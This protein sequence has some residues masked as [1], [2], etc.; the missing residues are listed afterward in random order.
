ELPALRVGTEV[1]PASTQASFSINAAPSTS[2]PAE[3][4]AVN[5]QVTV[6]FARAEWGEALGERVTWLVGQRLQVADIQVNPPQLGPI[7]L[8][9]SIQNDQASLFFSS[10]HAAVREAI[11]AAL[12]RL[13]DLLAQSGLALGHTSV[14]AESFSGQQQ[15][16]RQAGGHGFDP[17]QDRS[18]GD[19]VGAPSLDGVTERGLALLRGRG[20]V[21][22][23]V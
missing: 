13:G 12:P 10:S 22:M 18:G 17:D 6:P 15:A 20:G 8:R 9:I 5:T 7:E 3:T 21:D 1:T 11:Q 4:R 23:F 2:S 16:F 14:G 19:V